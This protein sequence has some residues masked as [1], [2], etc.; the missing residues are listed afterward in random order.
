ME[1]YIVDLVE[2]VG[3]SARPV[4]QNV[5]AG[6]DPLSQAGRIALRRGGFD[7][8]LFWSHPWALI[9]LCSK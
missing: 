7:V 4:S 3:I 5:V 2:L 8:G 9:S 1:Y 6:G